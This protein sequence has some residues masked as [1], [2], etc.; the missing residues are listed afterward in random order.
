MVTNVELHASHFTQW[1]S[2][3]PPLSELL[4]SLSFE[5]RRKELRMKNLSK[6]LE[7]LHNSAVQDD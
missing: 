5:L 3:L 7:G 1:I 6:N 4:P 2:C